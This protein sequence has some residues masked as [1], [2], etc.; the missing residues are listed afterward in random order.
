MHLT[1]TNVH[2]VLLSAFT[3]ALKFNEEQTYANGYL[4]RVG[5]VPAEE[6][7][8]MQLSFLSA[9]NWE[10]HIECDYWH[11]AANSL[12]QYACGENLICMLP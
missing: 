12:Y 5:G 10:L 9:I 2:R 4:A 1:P 3:L 8:R 7:I 11:R 6:L